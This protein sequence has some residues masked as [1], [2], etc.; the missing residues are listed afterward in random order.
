MNTNNKTLSIR[1]PLI[2]GFGVVLIALVALTV[3][4]ISRVEMVRARLDD[5]IDETA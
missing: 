5:I 2:A 1:A 4:A 3:I